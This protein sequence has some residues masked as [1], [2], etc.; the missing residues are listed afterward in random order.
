[1]ARFVPVLNQFQLTISQDGQ[2]ASVL[3]VDTALVT[4]GTVAGCI[5]TNSPYSIDRLP[6]IGDMMEQYFGIEIDTNAISIGE[7]N[8]HCES[9]KAH[10]LDNSGRIKQYLVTYT[11]KP[12]PDTY[13]E[14]SL[15]IGGEW[16]TLQTDGT[17][18]GIVFVNNADHI[19]DSPYKKWI[20]TA[21][22]EYTSYHSTL[23][24]A[25]KFTSLAGQDRYFSNYTGKV[26]PLF[27]TDGVWL[28]LGPQIDPIVNRVGQE[29][30]RRTE[31]YRHK[32][33]T[34]DDVLGLNGFGGWNL[35]YDREAKKW[36][37]TTPLLYELTEG[38]D[39]WP[40]TMPVIAVYS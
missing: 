11:T 17:K 34:G 36:D 27:V 8:L 1:M 28:L 26:Q 15:R 40:R 13:T 16:A 33:I 30:Y 10:M 31:I 38:T 29:R 22:Y 39:D 5:D 21:D 3:Y 37:T 18:D 9:V 19:L 32:F 35:I 2:S 7:L 23:E 20:F 24:D 4:A 25:C 12:V 14:Q 6:R